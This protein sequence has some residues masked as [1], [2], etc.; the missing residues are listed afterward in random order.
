LSAPFFDLDEHGDLRY[1]GTFAQGRPFLTSLYHLLNP[2]ETLKY[3]HADWPKVGDQQIRLFAALILDIRDRLKERYGIK[4]LI[5]SVYPGER[6]YI[7]RL[8]PIL[9][10]SLT[11]PWSTYGNFS[12]TEV[13]CSVTDIPLQRPIAFT[14]ILSPMKCAIGG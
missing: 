8:K 3:F 5:F 4:T 9:L 11:F 13:R 1:N 7:D 6:R 14:P 2:S 10:W 12:A